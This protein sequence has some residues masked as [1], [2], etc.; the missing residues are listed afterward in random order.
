M[1]A[2]ALTA[3]WL[4]DNYPDFEGVY[5]DN[6]PEVFSN[7]TDQEI[8]EYA[9]QRQ[10]LIDI[11]EKEGIE[12]RAPCFHGQY[13]GA[14]MKG[15]RSLFLTRLMRIRGLV[16]WLEKSKLALNVYNDAAW[17]TDPGN[18][19]AGIVAGFEDAHISEVGDIHPLKR[20]KSPLIL[21]QRHADMAKSLLK[22]GH[23]VV[24]VYDLNDDPRGYSYTQNFVV[25]TGRVDGFLRT[26]FG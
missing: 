26:I 7:G 8:R 18:N 4:R 16:P 23:P 11:L 2:H 22:A 6:E 24:A 19:V 9:V 1:Q 14:N 25:R 5:I 21:G 20:P 15:E 12:W 17:T 3:C 13:G 10:E